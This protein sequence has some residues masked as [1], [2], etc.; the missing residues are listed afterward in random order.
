MKRAKQ[1]LRPPSIRSKHNN[2]LSTEVRALTTTNLVICTKIGAILLVAINAMA[3]RSEV[4]R[5]VEWLAEGCVVF[6]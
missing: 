6:G 2:H 5:E 4:G 1:L 3:S